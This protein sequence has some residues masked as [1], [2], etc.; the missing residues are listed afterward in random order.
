ML[1]VSFEYVWLGAWSAAWYEP[2]WLEA[3]TLGQTCWPCGSPFLLFPHRRS[4]RA[5]PRRWQC[6]VIS[7]MRQV[8]VVGRPAVDG[9][10]S[11]P[12]PRERNLRPLQPNGTETPARL[13]GTGLSAWTAIS[14]PCESWQPTPL[15]PLAPFVVPSSTCVP[16]PTVHTPHCVHFRP[17]IV[18][19][20]VSLVSCLC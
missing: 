12:R 1:C 18:F 9:H 5:R 3:S 6:S 14:T 19:R 13:G 4:H 16:C 15:F 20:L 8:A 17:L 10:H 7:I 2:R 11:I